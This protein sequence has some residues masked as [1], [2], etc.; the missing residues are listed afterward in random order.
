[1]EVSFQKVIEWFTFYDGEGK[2]IKRKTEVRIDP[3][4]G[5]SSR[6]VFDPGTT[7]T[8]PDYTEVAQQ[9]EGV[10]CPFCPENI[11]KMTPVF[12][13]EISESGRIFAGEAIL[14]PN[15]FPYSKHNGVVTFSGNHYVKLDEF[16]PLMIK[17]AFIACQTY[18]KRVMLH[19]SRAKYASINWNYLPYSGGSIIHPHMHVIVSESPT[20]YQSKIQT[21]VEI[22]EARYGA[23]YFTSLYETEKKLGERWIGEHGNVAWIHAFAPK[24]HNDFIAIFPKAM[25]IHDVSENDWL[26]FSESIQSIF[27][28][29]KEQGFSSF[30]MTLILPDE[31]SGTSLH[32]R[33]IPR[34][35]I[36][37]LET[38]DMN[39]FQ[40]LHQEPLTYKIPEKI[41]EK[42]RNLFLKSKKSS[43]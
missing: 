32:V 11:L 26:D 5:E 34:F 36:G 31:S 25:S 12:P 35:T 28:V 18:I 19:D 3:L 43:F 42:A 10:N 22:F 14:F 21:E 16:T 30:N 7:F 6:L 24:S 38:S 40:V 39:F 8:P 20:N 13:K 17:D 27:A 41:A 1:M 37:M 2:Q 33:L 4:T 23:N 29:L 9:T 15:L